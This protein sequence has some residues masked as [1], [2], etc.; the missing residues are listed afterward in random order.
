MTA[1]NVRTSPGPSHGA[2]FLGHLILLILAYFIIFILQ[3]KSQALSART[4]RKI[5]ELF[6]STPPH[7]ERRHFG[8]P[9]LRITSFN[10]RSRM[11]SDI[12]KI[13]TLK[14]LVGFQSTLPHGERQNYA[15]E[16]MRMLQFQSTLPH[17]ER[18][19]N[20][21]T[22]WLGRDVSIHAP[23]WGATAPTKLYNH[24][25]SVSIHAPAWGATAK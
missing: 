6:Q 11:G 15:M 21:G 17:G 10:P 16:W 8:K 12:I 9:L 5:I 22:T 19:H 18:P 13:W 20:G 25:Q 2:I 1:P 23:A 3:K 4:S 14:C 24:C 7:G